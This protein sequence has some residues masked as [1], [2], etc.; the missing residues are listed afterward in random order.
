MAIVE[1]RNRMV[2]HLLVDTLIEWEEN[3]QAY[4]DVVEEG[5][6]LRG[7]QDATHGKEEF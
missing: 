6:R 4:V 7:N 5:R 2:G 3:A 1:R